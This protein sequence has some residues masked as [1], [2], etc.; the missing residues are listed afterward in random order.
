MKPL[1]FTDPAIGSGYY[2]DPRLA[3]S[4]GLLQQGSSTAPVRSPL[5]G[6]LRALSAGV[7]GFLQSSVNKGYR[8]REAGYQKALAD[9][10]ANPDQMQSILAGNP[11]TA[12]EAFGMVKAAQAAKLKAIQDLYAKGLMPGANGGLTAVPGYG[13][14]TGQNAAAA[15]TAQIPADVAKQGAMIPGAVSQATQTAQALSP[16]TTQTA[17]NTAAAT[18]PIE[19]Q[20]AVDTAARTAPITAAKDIGVYNST[21]GPQQKQNNIEKL[22]DDVR[23]DMNVKNYQTV[24]PIIESMKQAV[25]T[26]TRAA[27]LNLVYGI[28]KIMDP[29]SVV[30][31]GE[32]VLVQNTGNLGDRITNLL[33]AVV[34]GQRL[35][36]ET[37][38]QLYNEAQSRVQPLAQAYAKATDFYGKQAQAIGSNLDS[39]LYDMP[40]PGPAPDLPGIVPAIGTVE[41]GFRFNGGAPSDR[42]N[43]TKVPQ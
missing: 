12:P 36:P 38:A 21:Q 23:Q 9:A 4:Q 32:Q 5:E 18:A 39:V 33:S 26:D 7:G 37:R 19:I 3:Y 28:A 22:R 34:G 31:E 42:A 40:T 43:W 41:D 11:D 2:N 13:E 15:T 30:R 1:I 6:G 25:K 8:G 27:D 29:G 17:A 14:A 24:S 20:K 35:T 16:I 10:L